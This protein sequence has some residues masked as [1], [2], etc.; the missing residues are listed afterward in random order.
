MS[1]KTQKDQL[2]PTTGSQN[3]ASRSQFVKLA[4]LAVAAF[5]VSYL[6][7]SFA[8]RFFGKSSPA[9][10]TASVP[11]GMVWIPG[12]EFTMGTD[13]DLGWVEEKPAHRARVDGFWMDETDVTNAQFR[14]FVDAT[15]YVTTAEKAPNVD[16]IMAQMPPGTPRPP[17][18]KL[19]P[20]ALVFTP[21]KGP[22]PLNDFS[23]WWTWTPGANWRH[24]AGPA[25]SIEGKDDHPVVQVSW[26]DAVAYAKWDG[27]RLP[28]EAEWEFAARGGLDNKPYVWGDDP[29]TDT[30]IHANIWQG[31]FPYKNT[32]ADGFVN[33][34]PV[35]TFKPNGYGLYDMSG[36]VWQW[37]SD[38]YQMN[39][40]R[41]RAG[42]G[43]VINPPGPPKSF[44]P[45]QP[46]SPLRVQKGGSFLCNDSY[47]SRYR[48]SARHGCTPDT[49]MSHI[50][51]RC[52]RTADATEK[53]GQ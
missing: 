39:L 18:E 47:C 16:E 45:R 41:E 52:A 35:R 2:Q 33:T 27:K 21:T 8:P 44:D 11:P 51:F 38:W 4:P 3:S 23:Q 30:T 49:G 10:P 22:V 7:F 48:P 9:E 17:K 14:R 31:E 5:V 37:C 46:Y 32:A 40:Y 53:S 13:A 6:L 20:A 25:S 24:P 15:G 26:D 19:V 36:N 34:S 43:I 12:G 29:P 28:T 50:G 42:K 1:A